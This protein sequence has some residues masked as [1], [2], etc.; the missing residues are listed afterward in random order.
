MSS[1]IDVSYITPGALIGVAALFPVLSIASVGLRFYVRRIHGAKLLADDWLL[2]PALV[3][4]SFHLLSSKTL[5][6]ESTADR[7]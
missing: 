7:L 5:H 1:P 2:V 3:C 6:A 4:F